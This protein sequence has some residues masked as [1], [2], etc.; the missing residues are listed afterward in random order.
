MYIDGAVFS[1]TGA[2]G[3]VS[4]V[5]LHASADFDLG[6]SISRAMTEGVRR[7][8][9]HSCQSKDLSSGVGVHAM[10]YCF[11]RYKQGS[12]RPY[13]RS[14]PCFRIKYLSTSSSGL[15]ASIPAAADCRADLLM[16]PITWVLDWRQS[17]A[18]SS[19]AR[20]T[21]IHVATCGEKRG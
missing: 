7:N 2:L 9:R 6:S 21:A 18:R 15:F 13:F 10:R 20:T 14:R 5:T 8:L 4:G 3:E 12:R 17:S 11:M 16:L 1:M 19:G